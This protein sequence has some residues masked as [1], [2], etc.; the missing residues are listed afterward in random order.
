MKILNLIFLFSFLWLPSLWGQQ[1][2]QFYL[3]DAVKS[4]LRDRDLNHKACDSLPAFTSQQKRLMAD[5]Q[6]AYWAFYECACFHLQYNTL[7]SAGFLVKKAIN[8]LENPY[9]NKVDNKTKNL[10]RKYLAYRSYRIMEAEPNQYKKQN[11]EINTS[12]QPVDP[13]TFANFNNLISGSDL[14]NTKGIRFD[15]IKN[16]SIKF[17]VEDQPEIMDSLQAI[18]PYVVGAIEPYLDE[19]GYQVDSM[20]VTA[21]IPKN[22]KGLHTTEFY[23]GEIIYHLPYIDNDSKSSLTLPIGSRLSLKN[24]TILKLISVGWYFRLSLRY[25]INMPEPTY[26]VIEDKTSDSC[27]LAITFYLKKTTRQ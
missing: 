13:V 27:D 24:K 10:M 5:D 4:I 21:H 7:D 8:K 19:I 11:F 26:R 6:P 18:A 20:E 9:N 25:G 3:D 1:S 2:K 12:V 22:W 14:A 16:Q 15:E 17:I 23:Q